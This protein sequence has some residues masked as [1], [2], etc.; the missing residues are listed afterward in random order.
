MRQNTADDND[1][2]LDAGN[3]RRLDPHSHHDKAC[4]IQSTVEH[5]VAS[6]HFNSSLAHITARTSQAKVS[7]RKKSSTPLWRTMSPGKKA[8]ERPFYGR[9]CCNEK[10]KVPKKNSQAA[11]LRLFSNV[12]P[13]PDPEWRFSP[14]GAHRHR[15]VCRQVARFF[16]FGSVLPNN[17][18]KSPNGCEGI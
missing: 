14:D 18:Y 2:R 9:D 5:N 16:H 1:A 4:V 15:L 11:L 13:S 8:V 17:P 3:D 7:A 12:R 10:K 6:E